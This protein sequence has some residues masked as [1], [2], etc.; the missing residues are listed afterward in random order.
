MKSSITKISSILLALLVLLS[1]FSFTVKKHYCGEF[2]VGVSYFGGDQGC[3]DEA[4]EEDCDDPQIIKKKN[5][6]KD[7]ITQVEGQEELK[8]SAEKFDLEKQ[9]FLVAFITSYNDLFL[10]EAEQVNLNEYYSPPNL[11]LD[12]QVLYEVYLI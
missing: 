9:Q 12:L 4:G 10:E 3:G 8:N 11:N 2:L 1:T 6:C 7:E 5:C